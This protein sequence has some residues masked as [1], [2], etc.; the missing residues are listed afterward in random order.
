MAGFSDILF[1]A[2]SCCRIKEC[3]THCK[4]RYLWFAFMSII[5]WH[6]SYQYHSPALRMRRSYILLIA[7][8]QGYPFIFS[9][10]MPI[11]GGLSRLYLGGSDQAPP[12]TAHFPLKVVGKLSG[13]YY[14][15]LMLNRNCNPPD[16]QCMWVSTWIHSLDIVYSLS[17]APHSDYL[18]NY[19]KRHEVTV[20]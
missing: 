11:V 18:G 7:F 16:V 17:V 2:F 14:F 12:F 13:I 5:Q 1:W 8:Q 4:T 19:D 10:L 6:T 15:F 20:V 3:K 9:T